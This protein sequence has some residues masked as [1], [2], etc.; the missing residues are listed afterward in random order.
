MAPELYKQV[1]ITAIKTEKKD[2]KTFTLAET[3][4]QPVRY[5]AGQ[6]LT[7]VFNHHHKE[8]R[9][10][11]S[12]CSSPE[13]NEPLAFT[14]KRVENGAYSRWLT[15]RVAEGD[16]LYTT[17]AAGLFT[18]P[19]GI[20]GYKQVFFFAAGIG[21]TPVFSLIK[22]LLHTRPDLQIVLIYS[23]RTVEEAV[24]YEALTELA[25][26]FAHRFRIEFLYSTAFD[27]ARA[28]LSKLLLPT[29][30]EEYRVA[31]KKDLLFYLCGP[32]DYMRMVIITLEELGIDTQQIKRENFNT[33]SAPVRKNDPPD[34]GTHT[35]HVHYAGKV[36]DVVTAYPDSIL[37]AAK[38]QGIH[39]PYSCETGRCGSCAAL[40]TQGTVWLSYNEVLMD[41]DLAKGK[42]LTCVGHPVN[43]DVTLEI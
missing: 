31:E 39:L 15:D 25:G 6:F 16:I 26:R 38:K 11:F 27:L 4:G 35:A 30:L 41:A 2:V 33:N 42:T 10:S 32:S 8:E 12:I 28:R 40:C 14:V 34:K 5:A 37:Q 17:G 13:L 18:I 23:N 22:S 24:F 9:R 43:G 29:L 19:E 7:F 36:Y 1:V 3:D 20:A 21:I